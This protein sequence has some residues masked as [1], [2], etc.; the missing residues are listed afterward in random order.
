MLEYSQYVTPKKF[1]ARLICIPSIPCLVPK[2]G[3]HYHGK[4]NIIFFSKSFAQASP[5][6]MADQQTAPSID[7]IN[8]L[9]LRIPILLLLLVLGYKLLL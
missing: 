9:P 6:A 1:Y 4:A 8:K 2:T 5:D 3:H 7:R